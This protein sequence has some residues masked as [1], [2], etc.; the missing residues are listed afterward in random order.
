MLNIVHRYLHCRCVIRLSTPS[1]IEEELTLLTFAVCPRHNIR[2]VCHL[3]YGDTINHHQDQYFERFGGYRSFQGMI[4]CFTPNIYESL[5]GEKL[6]P[7]EHI[8][9][10]LKALDEFQKTNEEGFR[11]AFL[12]YAVEVNDVLERIGFPLP[13]QAEQA[14]RDERLRRRSAEVVKNKELGLPDF[15]D[16]NLSEEQ[17][18]DLR[19]S[20][21]VRELHEILDG[22]WS[23]KPHWAIED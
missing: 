3:D 10:A 22:K 19:D 11:K 4:Y 14:V 9:E 13:E 17:Q 12:E 7:A 20:P 23:G 2:S 21:M 16:F 1:H 5:G 8:G 18:R 15:T 6:L